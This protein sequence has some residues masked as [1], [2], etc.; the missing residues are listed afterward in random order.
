VSTTRRRT[1]V[2]VASMGAVLIAVPAV[3]A[4][5]SALPDVAVTK[6]FQPAGSATTAF[7]YDQHGVPQGATAS[8][9]SFALDG[10]TA[11]TLE[12]RGLTAFR[13]YGAHLHVGACTESPAG[14]GGHWHFPDSSEP[15]LEE[16]EVWLD[17]T[18]D[19]QGYA[20]SVALRADS[21]PTGDRPM[22][23]VVHAQP[24]DSAT[25]AAGARLACVTVPF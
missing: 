15:A 4:V 20:K 3:A 11:V 1:L 21:I 19:E 7:T 9:Q 8:V 25:G 10:T 22:S 12:L 17:V 13:T 18:T 23:V 24:T 2:L 16:R 14:A 5:R 6:A